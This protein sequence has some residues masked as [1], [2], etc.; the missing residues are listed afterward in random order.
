M[1]EYMKDSKGR[2][3]PVNNV[4]VT[5]KLRDD[6]VNNLVAAAKLEQEGLKAF[7]KSSYEDVHA[8]VGLVAAEH[9]VKF[10]GL[11]GNIS[12]L[13]FDGCRKVNVAISENI[14]FDESLQVAKDK[15]DDLLLEW[16]NGA[17]E[18]IRIIIMD[19]FK[20]DQEGKISVTRLLELRRYEVQDERWKDAM[21]IISNSVVIAGSKSYIRFYE[22][23]T[24][25]SEWC[26]ISLDIAK[27]EV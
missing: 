9:D 20:V 13:S 4:K 17:N 26:A 22:R 8:F 14:T 25:E 27:L 3:V 10:G 24:P 5:D 16:S 1:A 2:L 11:K 15:L 12:L 19:A 7:K 23:E 18:N 21:N 6:V